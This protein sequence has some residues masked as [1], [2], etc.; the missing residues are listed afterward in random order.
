MS[1]PNDTPASCPCGTGKPLSACCGPFHDGS[2]LPRTAEQ[3][4]R[5]RYSAFALQRIDYLRETLWPAYQPGFDAFS[6]AKWAAENHWAGLTILDK[7]QGGT[8]DRQGTILFEARYL[9][10]GNLQTHRENSLFKKKS[11]RWYYVKAV[12]HP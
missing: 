9:F 8:K 7:S 2:T 6:T 12:E 1:N 4:M 10:A 5:S 11:G 3:L